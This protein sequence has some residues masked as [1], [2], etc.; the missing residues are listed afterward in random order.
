MHQRTAQTGTTVSLG[1]LFSKMP[2]RYSEFKR[3][4]KR[5]FARLVVLLQAYCM[6]CTEV[7]FMCTNQP[8]KGSTQK[9]LASSPGK[10]VRDQ[11]NNIFG[12]KM[13]GRGC[14]RITAEA[15]A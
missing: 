9:V 13:V 1:R 8:P 14:G 7:R 15:A 3:N 11:I 10:S 5:E 6:V 12:A 4:I 2:V